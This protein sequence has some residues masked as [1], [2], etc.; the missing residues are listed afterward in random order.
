[1]EERVAVV[2]GANRG[3]GREVCRQLAR[4]GLRVILSARNVE[5]GQQAARELEAEGLNVQF[6]ILDVVDPLSAR[7]LVKFL[8]DEVGR[9]DVLVNNAGIYVDRGLPA[10]QVDLALVRQTME[11]NFYGPLRLSQMVLP[12][13][14]R[15][16]Y[17]RIVNVSSQMG[18]LTGMG[19]GALGYRVS[20]TGLN[21]MTRI[22]AAEM[23]GSNI[24]I[25]AVDPGWVSTDMGGPQ[26]PRSLQEG[27][28]SVA[29]LAT[30]PAGGPSGGFFRDRREQ[31]W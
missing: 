2:T 4:L 16:D 14:Q 30:L 26:A 25:N 5:K 27:A 29:W 22:L 24:L 3:I 6:H 17:G 19:S 21:A 31:P 20:K 1:M 7:R 8:A 12:L 15:H 18:A 13:M 23:R 11:T 28:E 10:S 9:L